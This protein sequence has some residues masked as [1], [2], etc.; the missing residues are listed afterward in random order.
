MNHAVADPI[1]APFPVDDPNP[2][3]IRG[4]SGMLLLRAL[5]KLPYV[6]GG[7]VRGRRMAF[8]PFA[9]YVMTQDE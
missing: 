3:A 7:E 4:S 6:S 5:Q 2:G 9:G 8:E 1:I